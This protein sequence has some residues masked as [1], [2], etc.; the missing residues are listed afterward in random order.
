MNLVSPPE[1]DYLDSCSGLR[2][3][4][5]E[6]VFGCFACTSALA[7]S[8]GKQLLTRSRR[9]DG[10]QAPLLRTEVSLAS[11]LSPLCSNGSLMLAESFSISS[12]SLRPSVD[13]QSLSVLMLS[14]R[15]SELRF[16]ELSPHL[17]RI[18]P[19]IEPIMTLLSR[20]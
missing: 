11:A 15:S 18:L 3:H 9:E 10:Q 7:T 8:Q 17:T 20:H 12:S 2:I 14:L 6:V 1:C 16:E 5:P 19:V 4:W 13:G